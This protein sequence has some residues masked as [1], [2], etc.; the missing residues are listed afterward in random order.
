MSHEAF[1]ST[2]ATVIPVLFFLVAF[3]RRS[4]TVPEKSKGLRVFVVGVLPVAV[5]LLSLFAEWLAVKALET[6]VDTADRRE[7]IVYAIG[8]LLSLVGLEAIGIAF[9]R[10]GRPGSPARIE[11]E[12]HRHA[13]RDGAGARTGA[14]TGAQEPDPAEPSG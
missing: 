5:I 3:Q 9:G 6:G 11:Y 4:L 7:L 10:F 8:L 12:R 1:Y 2:T 14:R 13:E